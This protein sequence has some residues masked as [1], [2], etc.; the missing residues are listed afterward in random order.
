MDQQALNLAELPCTTLAGVGPRLAEKLAKCGIQSVQDL[1]FYMPLHYQDRTHISPIGS[2]R[3]GDTVVIEG[4][5][6]D[7]SLSKQRRP[8]LKYSCVMRVVESYCVIFTIQSN[9]KIPW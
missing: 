1:L 6:E 7:V 9:K 5:V 3:V 4:V 2:L 8:S